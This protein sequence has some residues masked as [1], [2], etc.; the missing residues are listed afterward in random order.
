VT[1]RSFDKTIAGNNVRISAGGRNLLRSDVDYPY[2]YELG[3]STENPNDP[4]LKRFE[5]GNIFAGR[6]IQFLLLDPTTIIN[7][8]YQGLVMQQKDPGAGSLVEVYVTQHTNFAIA[9]RRQYPTI[10]DY[11]G[12]RGIMFFGEANVVPTGPSPV[13]G[14]QLYVDPDDST[15]KYRK[16]DGTTVV[17]G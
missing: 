17:L 10:D 3:A 14:I 12:G 4:T 15:L 16:P 7:G 9:A 6:Y 2:A 5:V 13:A 11:G 1:Y 8:D